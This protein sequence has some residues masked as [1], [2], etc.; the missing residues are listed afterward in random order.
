MVVCLC[1]AVCDRVI[2]ATIL[3]GARTPDDIRAACGAGGDCRGCV[4][5]LDTLLDEVLDAAPARS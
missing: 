4:G 5:A 1:R 2:R 3:A